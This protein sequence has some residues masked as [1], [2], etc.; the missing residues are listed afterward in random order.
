MFSLNN[1]RLP[2]TF[3]AVRFFAENHLHLPPVIGA[4]LS[5]GV[6][7]LK[8]LEGYT[9][10][11]TRVWKPHWGYFQNVA[12]QADSENRVGSVNFRK[13]YPEEWSSLRSLQLL[14][15]DEEV[16]VITQDAEAQASAVEAGGDRSGAER[17]NAE[18]QWSAS[19]PHSPWV[20]SPVAE[21]SHEDTSFDSLD[22]FLLHDDPDLQAVLSQSRFELDC[23]LD[24]CSSSVG[25]SQSAEANELNGRMPFGLLSSPELLTSFFN[26]G[27][28]YRD[29]L[30]DD[31]EV[32][33]ELAVYPPMCN[34]V[35]DAPHVVEDESLV[36]KT[37]VGSATRRVVVQRDDDL[38]TP[39]Q[40]K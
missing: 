7:L 9:G 20:L 19:I 17:G 24:A 23:V 3:E 2:G 33:C 6:G 39:D 35:P 12:Q 36:F 5:L 25:E 15:G 26:A 1:A 27:F 14:F 40:V 22:A 8:P 31:E 11:L 30:Y 32:L 18:G 13:L 38:L 4:R 37:S 10:A 34:T 21:G 16:T 29:V 28:D